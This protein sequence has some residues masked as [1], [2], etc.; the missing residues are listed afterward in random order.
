MFY[1]KYMNNI[2]LAMVPWGEKL[3]VPPC[4]RR[5]IQKGTLLR[6]HKDYEER[7]RFQLLCGEPQVCCH[8]D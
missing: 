1:K 6:Q 2:F 8:R 4:V 7:T 3:K 5:A